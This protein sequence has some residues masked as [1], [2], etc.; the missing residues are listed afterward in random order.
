MLLTDPQ[1]LRYGRQVIVPDVGCEGQVKLLDSKV[2]IV[3]LGGLGCPV[4]TY[5]AGSG[6]G[7]LYLSEHD[8]V[9]RSNLHRQTLYTRQDIN[10]KKVEAAIRQLHSSNNQVTYIA[11]PKL[12]ESLADNLIPKVDVVVDCTDNM[13]ARQI[14]NAACVKHKKPFVSA[15]VVGWI[16]YTFSYEPNNNCPCYHCLFENSVE[17]N[18]ETFGVVGAVAGMVG[19][20]QAIMTLRILLNLNRD[21]GVL[22]TFNATTMSWQTI[23]L[24]KQTNCE[25]CK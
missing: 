16:G 10:G 18:C 24:D 13:E 25:V 7:T 9:S 8:T 23:K 5:L 6:V 12:S 1:L 15:G 19:S 11:Q 2:L 21:I 14:I 3:G 17:Q 22:K 4:A 20:M